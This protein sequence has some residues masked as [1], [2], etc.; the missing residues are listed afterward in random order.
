MKTIDEVA[1]NFRERTP[2][3]REGGAVRWRADSVHC[4]GRVLYRHSRPA[5]VYLGAAAVSATGRPVKSRDPRPFFATSADPEHARGSWGRCSFFDRVLRHLPGVQ[6]SFTA[7]QAAG[8]R[9]EDLALPSDPTAAPGPRLVDRQ[10]HHRPFPVVLRESATGK[11]FAGR[12]ESAGNLV[13]DGPFVVPSQG[14]FVAELNRTRVPDG[15]VPGCW[16]IADGCL[17]RD[18]DKYLVCG[19]DEGQYFVAQ[20]RRPAATVTSAFEQLKPAPVRRAARLGESIIRQGEWFFQKANVDDK[21]LAELCQVSKTRLW[22][23]LVRR[24]T[25]LPDAPHKANRHRA[26]LLRRGG[27]LYV[28]GRV[29]HCDRHGHPT[30]EHRTLY[31]DGWHLAYP[32]TEVRSWSVTG[33]F[34]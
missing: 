1:R 20:L 4:D 26:T 34:D 33:R 29:M 14:V 28:T 16:H 30:R 23:Q 9:V 19:V 6:L 8:V 24:N 25:P 11:Y 15:F 27:K 7:L 2:N 13:L 32:N 21:Q 12:W 10:D 5:A 17:I 31:L 3:P 22:K 18:D